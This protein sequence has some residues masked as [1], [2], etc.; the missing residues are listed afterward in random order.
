M[1]D[2]VLGYLDHFAAGEGAQF[3]KQIDVDALRHKP[4]GSVA[5]KEVL[6]TGMAAP[7]TAFAGQTVSVAT[8]FL[9]AVVVAVEHAGLGSGC[10]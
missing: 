9:A 3:G 6:P 1:L 5:E 7:P 10:R 2:S 8:F 4:D